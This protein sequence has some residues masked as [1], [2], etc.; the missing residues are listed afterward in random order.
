ME[1]G[2]GN[3]LLGDSGQINTNDKKTELQDVC[4]DPFIF[5]I[6]S[7]KLA[8]TGYLFGIDDSQNLISK[9]DGGTKFDDPPAERLTSRQR[10]ESG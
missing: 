7:L 10:G 8:L 4:A 3:D 5:P 1:I 6:S 2:V 9:A